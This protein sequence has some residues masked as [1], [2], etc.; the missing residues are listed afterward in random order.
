MRILILPLACALICSCSYASETS[1]MPSDFNSPHSPLHQRAKF[2]SAL[3]DP[4]EQQKLLDDVAH[5]CL[6][7]QDWQENLRILNEFKASRFQD[8]FRA[9]KD[10]DLYPNSEENFDAFETLYRRIL[11]RLDIVE[12]KIQMQRAEAEGVKLMRLSE[13]LSQTAESSS[14]SSQD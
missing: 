5:D 4:L 2:S 10:S 6:K 13:N 11:N 7:S 14:L 9:A 8:L 3:D 1:L 12:T